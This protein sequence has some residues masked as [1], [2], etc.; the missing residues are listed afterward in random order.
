MPD[1]IEYPLGREKRF[2]R[3]R[4][5]LILLSQAWPGAH[6]DR[7]RASGMLAG[8]IRRVVTRNGVGATLPNVHHESRSDVYMKILARQKRRHPV[9]TDDA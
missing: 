4:L 5:H 2:Q 6:A 8:T 3:I 9:T 7:I 1:G